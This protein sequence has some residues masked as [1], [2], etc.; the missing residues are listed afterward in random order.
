MCIYVL[1]AVIINDDLMVKAR[2]IMI[3]SLL[4]P[5]LTAKI[6]VVKVFCGVR[7]LFISRFFYPAVLFVVITHAP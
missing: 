6:Y 1:A 7:K 4:T 5:F 3:I 2:E